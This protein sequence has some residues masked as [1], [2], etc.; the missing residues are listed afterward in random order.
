MDSY[1]I[2]DNYGRPFKIILSEN[3]LQKCVEVLTA[4][5]EIRKRSEQY[6]TEIE[7]GQAYVERVLSTEYKKLFINMVEVE[8]KTSCLYNDLKCN[9]ILVHQKTEYNK[10]T[11][12]FI[13]SNIYSF[14]TD[15]DDK[16]VSFSGSI[17]NA[18]L[19]FAVGKK[20]TYDFINTVKIS[21][22]FLNALGPYYIHPFNIY[23]G[24]PLNN[25][26]EETEK[27][28]FK[29]I[30]KARQQLFVPFKFKIIQYRLQWSFD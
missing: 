21:S 18:N 15:L 10:H 28:V 12:I 3:E 2:Y 23:T 30:T 19:P 29:K 4:P 26:E 8:Q 7:T 13:G 11:Y 14:K 22:N 6:R 16:I 25:V 5:Y 20:F 9:S 17:N 27:N 1:Y 24:L